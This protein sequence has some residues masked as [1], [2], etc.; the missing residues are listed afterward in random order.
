MGDIAS[1]IVTALDVASDPALPEVVCR[2]QQLQAIDRGQAVDLSTCQE[3]LPGVGAPWAQN[4]LPVLRGYVW[5]QQN[6]WVYPAA[7]LAIIGIP[8]WIGYELGKGK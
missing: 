2:I 4:A 6:K 8:M 3:T 7:V 1:T 5:A